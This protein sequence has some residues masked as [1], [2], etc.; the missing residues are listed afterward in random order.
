[1]A[2]GGQAP[3]LLQRANHGR[4]RHQCVHIRR[5]AHHRLV[6]A[7]LGLCMC[8]AEPAA[9]LGGD[10]G[11]RGALSDLVGLHATISAVQISREHSHEEDSDG[12]K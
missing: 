1:M 5:D 2:D 4:A 11:R 10:R 6:H 12:G 9:A 3:V 7:L 8:P